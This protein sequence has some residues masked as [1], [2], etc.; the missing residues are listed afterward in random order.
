MSMRQRRL[1][2]LD[3]DDSDPMLSSIN[4]VDVFLVAIA[5]LMI[6]LMN[7]PLMQ[8]AESDF[9]LIR[10]EGKPTMEIVVK[11]GEKLSHF[12]AT[13]ASSEGNGMKAGTAYRMNDGS[14]VYVPNDLADAK[15]K[16]G[17]TP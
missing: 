1:Q 11:K 14:M 6:S 15:S 8:L 9:S 3:D 16:T 7:N 17:T 12:Q 2:I 10:D 13:G 5:I 4:L